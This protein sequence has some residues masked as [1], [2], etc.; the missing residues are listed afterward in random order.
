MWINRLK[1]TG[2]TIPDSTVGQKASPVIREV[3]KRKR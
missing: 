3:V 1:K 2:Y